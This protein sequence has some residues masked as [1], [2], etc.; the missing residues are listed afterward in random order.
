MT[1][2]KD[3]D[4]FCIRDRDLSFNENGSSV[5]LQN[6]IHRKHKETRSSKTNTLKPKKQH[7][8]KKHSSKSMSHEKKGPQSAKNGYRY[9]NCGVNVESVVFQGIL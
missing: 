1:N 8:L 3:E 9:R 6:S 7:S 5:K 4:L 2:P